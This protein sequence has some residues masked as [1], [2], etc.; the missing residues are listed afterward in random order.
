MNRRIDWLNSLVAQHEATQQML[1]GAESV[2]RG[3]TEGI[4]AVALSEPEMLITVITSLVLVI[5]KQDEQYA[6][7]SENWLD[8]L[9][10]N[11]QLIK[12]IQD[13]AK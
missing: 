2:V 1:Q 12:L 8:S 4:Q 3:G 9:D 7:L 6:S 10:R 5:R 13:A 11:D